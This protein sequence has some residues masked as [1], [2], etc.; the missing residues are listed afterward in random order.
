MGITDAVSGAVTGGQTGPATAGA[1]VAGK[2]IAGAAKHISWLLLVLGVF[3]YILRSEGSGDETMRDII[4]GQYTQY[5]FMIHLVLNR[6][7]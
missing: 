4:Y 3:H 5:I 1:Y 2:E 7:I 6:A